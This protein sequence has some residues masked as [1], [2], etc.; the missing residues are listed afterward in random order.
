MY[1][2]LWRFSLPWLGDVEFSSYFTLVVVGFLLATWRVAR[3]EELAGRSSRPIFVLGILALITGLVGA[4]ALSVL[5]EGRLRDFVDLCVAPEK[6]GLVERNCFAALEFW[7][8]GLAYYGG[9]MLAVPVG[10]W[11]AKRAN[12]GAWRLSDVV[13]PYAALGLF[14]GR[15]GCFLAGCC[16]GK[17]TSVQWGMTFPQHTGERVHPTQLYEAA[18]ALVLY[19]FLWLVVRPR[20]RAHGQVS[21]AL[22]LG[23]G[24]LRFGLEFL[25]DDPRGGFSGL[26]TSQ[27]I[28]VPLSLLG[29]ILLVA[30]VWQRPGARSESE[31]RMVANPR[32]LRSPT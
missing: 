29:V 30:G 20:K 9:F 24:A 16:Y 11:Y 15:S 27:W 12:L 14:F 18:G 10:F 1:P 21:G 28:G 31:F 26:S 2:I 7:H 32:P 22:L 23:Y 13:A 25:R 3:E 5:V 8:G 4:R 17:P 19:A 6:L